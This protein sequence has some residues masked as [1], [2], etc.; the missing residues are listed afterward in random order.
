MRRSTVFF[1]MNATAI[2]SQMVA[3]LL[4]LILMRVSPWLCV[5]C[6]ILLFVPANLCAFFFSET[7]RDKAGLGLSSTTAAAQPEDDMGSARGQLRRLADATVWVVHE[8][9]FARVLLYT[10]LATTVGRSSQEILLQYVTRRY[11]WS[12][13]DVGDIPETHRSQ[14]TPPASFGF[15]NSSKETYKT[16]RNRPLY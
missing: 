2:G 11:R 8:R 5:F 16:H 15:S 3:S 10:L 4:A 7:P 9:P 14:A 1:Y 6:G 13:S 12:W